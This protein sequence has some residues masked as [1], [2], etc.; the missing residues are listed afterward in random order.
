MSYR[1]DAPGKPTFLSVVIPVLNEAANIQAM[2][3]RLRH[4]LCDTTDCYEVLFVSDGSTDETDRLVTD[5]NT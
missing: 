2:V 3:D 1:A 5:A 4:A